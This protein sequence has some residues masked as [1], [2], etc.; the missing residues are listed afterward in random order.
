MKKFK[1]LSLLLC[2]ALLM[3]CL[4]LPA[5]ATETQTAVTEETVFVSPEPLV[6][7]DAE[8]PFGTVCIQKGCR[9]INGM[10]PLAGS[11]KRLDTAVSAFLYET[12]TGTVIYS[13]NPDMEVGSGTLS[14]LVTAMVVL[15][16]CEM[17]ETI[18]VN[19]NNISKLAGATNLNIKNGETFT[20]EDLL[21]CLLMYNA[22]DAAIVLTE[23]V[24]GNQGAFVTLMNEKV[25]AIG[26]T[27]T[28]FGNVHGLDTATNTTTARDIT[29][30]MVAVLGYEDLADILG[31]EMY[32]VPATE[33]SDAREFVTTNY[34]LSNRTIPDF[35]DDRVKGGMQSMTTATGASVVI[36]AEYN[37][38][39][40]VAVVMGATRTYKE[41]G[42]SVQS[43]GNFNEMTEL[44][45]YAFNNFKLNRI[46]YEGMSMSQF[47]VNNGESDVVGQALVDIDSVVPK[48]AQMKNFQMNFTT[49]DGG[50]T[51]PI[52]KDE[53]I[54]TVQIVYRNSVVT[55][56]EVYA[57]G[58]VK[59]ADK[60]GVTIRSTAVR[61]DED[62][63]GILS[64][65]GTI[66]VIALGLA[67]CYLA[68]NAYMRSRIR[69][70]RRKR[71]ADRR[72]LR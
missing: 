56:A 66:S 45:T 24:A 13:Y 61:S 71:R 27:H 58:N 64:V 40:F 53:L 6:Q 7:T 37:N 14:K 16:H 38:M 21:C 68:F 51:A 46:V 9:T 65:I 34:F 5:A 35:L 25:R 60:T 69:A 18:T 11:D 43:Y 29:K 55:E 57:M 20:V 48:S 3:Q 54:A 33:K 19:T 39:K 8:I 23:Y 31:R 42:W 52:Q 15:D 44:M 62:D 70:K 36:N 2:L 32:E 63:S 22:N 1:H 59:A 26:C 47:R 4:C 49:V 10:V 50:L 28:D 72:R 67:I 17:N 12:T 30:I 41:N